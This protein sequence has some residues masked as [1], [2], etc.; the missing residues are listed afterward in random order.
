MLGNAAKE[1]CRIVDVYVCVGFLFVFSVK[2]CAFV[3]VLLGG[4]WTRRH[5]YESEM[6]FLDEYKAHVRHVPIDSNTEKQVKVELFKRNEKED[7]KSLF[8]YFEKYF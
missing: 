6:I 2:Q 5:F 1:T 7:E 4:L 8:Y 3:A